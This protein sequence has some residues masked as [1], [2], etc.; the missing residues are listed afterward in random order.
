MMAGNQNEQTKVRLS[1][2]WRF[3]SRFSGLWRREMLRQDTNVSEA[4][5]SRRP[6]FMTEV[7]EKLVP[8]T[9]MSVTRQVILPESSWFYSLS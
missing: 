3:K 4:S 5:Q 7:I 6:R 9:R 8:H 1:R 2:W